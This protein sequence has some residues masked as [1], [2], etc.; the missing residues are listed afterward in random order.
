MKRKLR[1]IRRSSISLDYNVYRVEVPM[2][3][4]AGAELSVIDM[5][6]EAVERTML[7]VHGYLGGAETWEYQINYFSY[8]HRV[9]VPDLRGHGQSDAPWSEYTMPEL[10]ADLHA[11]V[12]Q[13]QFPERFVLVGHSFGGSIC[14]EYAHA[15]PERL[16]HLILISTAGEYPLPRFLTALYRLPA[17]FFRP[18]WKY[19][20]RWNAEIPAF[21]RMM[22]NN[23]RQWQ[24][25]DL[26][27]Q[28]TVPTLVIIG[29]REQ[30][31]PSPGVRA[32]GRDY[33]RGGSNRRGRVQAQ[34][35]AR[36]PSGGEPGHRPLHRPGAIAG[37]VAEPDRRRDAN[38]SP[39][40][41]QFLMAAIRPSPCPCLAC[42]STISWPAPPTTCP[43][44]QPSSSTA[45]V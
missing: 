14:L 20:P 19:L 32:G 24:G 11:I 28:I 26:M 45:I 5:W 25:W 7:F 40:L 4:E 17:T 33:P 15:Y 6:P 21:K 34:G 2:P 30:L 36:T 8:D 10:V 22:M 39:A 23:L 29:E 3:G 35:A 31:L 42:P 44:V 41:D 12:R 18:W 43:S 16:E 37:V 13:R 27:R 9:V 38:R 1:G